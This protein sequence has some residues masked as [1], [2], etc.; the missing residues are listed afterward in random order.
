M[1]GANEGLFSSCEIMSKYEILY[2]WYTSFQ[3]ETYSSVG[4]ASEMH[5]IKDDPIG[6]WVLTTIL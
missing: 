5:N 2:L 6:D 1:P 3:V 4:F